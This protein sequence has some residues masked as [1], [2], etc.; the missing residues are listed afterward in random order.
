MQLEMKWFCFSEGVGKTVNVREL[1][2]N[3]LGHGKS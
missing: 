2:V 1:V 3:S